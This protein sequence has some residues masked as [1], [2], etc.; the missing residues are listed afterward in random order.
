[1]R[2]R[3]GAVFTLAAVMVLFVA[4]LG[5]SGGSSEGA[6]GGSSTGKIT[7]E[8]VV[9]SLLSGLNEQD[10]LML[11]AL[12]GAYT[13][14][15]P[16]VTFNMEV[17]AG[18]SSDV[19]NMIRTRLATGSMNDIFY[20]NSGSLLQTLHPS[21]TLVDISKDPYI[22]NISKAFIPT[23]SDSN[24][25]YGVPVGYAASGGVLYNKKVF[26]KYGLS[27]PKSWAE[28]EANNEK[29]KAAGVAPVI[30]TYGDNWT[31]QLFVLGDYYSVHLANPDFADN[32]TANKA[33]FATTPAALEGFKH[34]QE[35]YQKGWY[36][37]DFA[38]A[39]FQQG[40]EMLA[41]GTVPQ[42]PMLTQVMPTVVANWPDKAS[43]VGF[44]AMPGPSAANNGATVWMPLGL[45]MPKTS[46][47]VDI[48]R[49]FFGLVA[50]T[51]GTEA[52]TVKVTPAGPYLINGSTLPDNVLPFVK[53]LNGYISSGNAYPALEFL[54]P[55]KGPNLP[56]FCVAVGT[57]QMTP[58]EAAA[59][60]DKDV[61]KQ[62]QQLGLPGW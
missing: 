40:L 36:E 54:S 25:I 38:T 59:A 47:H 12:T 28:F 2:T 49:D 11:N 42:Y 26:A 30:Q 29:L 56:S 8:P 21:Q 6:A 22:A 43:D 39:K 23:V 48:G 4:A 58:E 24:G 55:I 16:N 9:L 61:E 33:K 27:V 14:K 18:Q 44:F 7:S 19:E 10:K 3:K 57:G 52:L 60:Y 46:K 17:P 20:F 50:S 53:D 32:Y 51:A 37:K 31:S 45:F 13:A 34:L 62:A 41:N 15:H 1:M 35:G 5:W